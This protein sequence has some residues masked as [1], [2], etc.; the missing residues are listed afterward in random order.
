[1]NLMRDYD[2]SNK[3]FRFPCEQML[4]FLMNLGEID[5][6]IKEQCS[7]SP[8]GVCQWASGYVTCS[9]VSVSYVGR[10]SYVL[11]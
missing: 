4:K 5:S 8:L 10:G 11:V 9:H 2:V 3:P 7:N 6:E 1:M